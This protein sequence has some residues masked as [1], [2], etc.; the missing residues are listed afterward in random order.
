MSRDRSLE[1]LDLGT[2]S[3]CILL[4]IIAERAEAKG[5]GLDS[6]PNALTIAQQNAERLG[7]ANR[8]HWISGE[9][10]AARGQRFDLIVANPPYIPS[11]DLST[12]E[13]DIRNFEPLRA[14]DGG[15]DGLSAYR[16][17][18]ALLPE[19]LTNQGV[20]MLEGGAGQAPMI[21]HILRDAGLYT[22]VAIRDA[23]GHERVVVA[24]RTQVEAGK[25]SEMLLEYG[26]ELAMFRA[27]N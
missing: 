23:L 3:G 5:T 15:L 17:I 6:D 4:S 16:Q 22:G 18:A 13:R 1:L 19:V 27:G 24:A 21:R 8:C 7:V 12:L 2:G 26:G 9:W 20:A 10:R 11:A 14:L 25:I